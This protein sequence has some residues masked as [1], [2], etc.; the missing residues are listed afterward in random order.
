[1]GEVGI[2][3]GATKYARS[4]MKF[5]FAWKL[6]WQVSRNPASVGAA[7][8]LPGKGRNQRPGERNDHAYRSQRADHRF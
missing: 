8:R 5:V 1:M 7:R 6:C 2:D 3:L 4:A